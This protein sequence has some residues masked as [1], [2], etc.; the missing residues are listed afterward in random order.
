MSEHLQPNDHPS[1]SAHPRV[2]F[3]AAFAAQTPAF[4]VASMGALAMIIGGLGPWATQFNYISISGTS[5]HG[6]RAVLVALWGL[7][8]LALYHVSGRRVALILAAVA[9]ALGA[10]QAIAGLDTISSGG[11][12]NVLGVQYRYMNPAWGLY[13]LL[14]GSLT[15]LACASVLAWRASRPARLRD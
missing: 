1:A 8:M 13:L 10:M 6:W 4:W 11:A 12:V 9:G 5:M 2:G 7:A 14:I 3:G 15:L